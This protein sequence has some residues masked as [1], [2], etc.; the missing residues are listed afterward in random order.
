M[1]VKIKVQDKGLDYTH[2]VTGDNVMRDLMVLRKELSDMAKSHLYE[3]IRYMVKS[4]FFLV[5][6]QPDVIVEIIKSDYPIFI[7]VRSYD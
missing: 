2:F 5:N 4:V 6:N 7:S 3:Q 1:K